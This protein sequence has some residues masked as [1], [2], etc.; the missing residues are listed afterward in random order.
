MSIRLKDLHSLYQTVSH[1]EAVA[2]ANLGAQTYLAAKEGLFEAWNAAQGAEEGERTERWRREG[3]EAMLASLKARLA[4]GEA[5]AARVATL[6]ASIEAE[7]VGRIDQVLVTQRKDFELAKMEEILCLKVQIAEAKGKETMV[8]KLDEAHSSM[9]AEI[10]ALKAQLAEKIAVKTKSSHVIGKEGEA[11]VLEMLE[12][13]IKTVF[14]YSEIKDMTAIHH[15]AD[16]HVWIMTP[17]G[18]RI[19][20]L[21]DSK[22]YIQSVNSA[23]VAKLN[24]DVDADE[25]AH[26]GILISLA[27]PI[28]AKK[29]FQIKHTQKQKPIIY[30][31]FQ[32]MEQI[33]KKDILCWA[34]QAL[35]AVVG[36]A[37]QGERL[38]MLET[39]DHL[40]NG[41]SASVKD[42]DLAIRSQVKAL[43]STRQARSGILHKLAS[44]KEGVDD[45]EE[46][47]TVEHVEE[48]GC[49]TIMK[50]SGV[51]CGKTVLKGT[52]KCRHHTS[53]KEK[54]VA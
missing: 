1:D 47:D 31:T 40:L 30:L 51:R 53:R 12:D 25:E 22:N 34:I 28:S 2:I 41:I 52:T 48:E 46:G 10:A 4:A 14:P 29:Q 21:I 20:F 24:K 39:I 43:E 13:I 44:F 36:E 50:A 9:A 38:Q 6:Q 5:A 8:K 18:K 54:A 17:S 16:F 37:D 33:Q 19:K 45:G 7:V 23:E 42:I 3:G 27:T 32:D 49:V 26:C 35:L 11:T 15:A